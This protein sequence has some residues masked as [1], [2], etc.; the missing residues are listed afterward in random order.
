MGASAITDIWKEKCANFLQVLFLSG[1]IGS[2]ITPVI[3]RPFLLPSNEEEIQNR[4]NSNINSSMDNG[5]YEQLISI[6]TPDD[7]MVH[8]AF[9]IFGV[10][11]VIASVPFVFFYLND[12][13]QNLKTDNKQDQSIDKNNGQKNHKGLKIYIAVA[14]V[15]FIGHS[16]YGVEMVLGEFELLIPSIFQVLFT[17]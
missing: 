9:L 8:I 14:L 16:V 13:K 5:N 7:V 3:T 11:G 12:R 6:Y 2:L 10:I 17:F 1:G 4:V 15:G